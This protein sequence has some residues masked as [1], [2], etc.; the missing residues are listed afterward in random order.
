MLF[1]FFLYSTRA[2]CLNDWPK[3]VGS[4]I[5]TQKARERLTNNAHEYYI[6][7]SLVGAL[8][9]CIFLFVRLGG[10]SRYGC[11]EACGVKIS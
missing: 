6:M 3:E 11:L 2:Y 10:S 9:G 7:Y 1:I 4:N 8:K 5:F